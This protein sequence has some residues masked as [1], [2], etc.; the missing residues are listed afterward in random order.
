[1]MNRFTHNTS[2]HQ[3][4][5]QTNSNHKPQIKNYKEN[6]PM[7]GLTNYKPPPSYKIVKY[8]DKIIRKLT[9]SKNIALKNNIELITK[10]KKKN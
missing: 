8:L 6:I 4:I 2:E 5:L 9:F 7:R 3:K 10:K 1:M